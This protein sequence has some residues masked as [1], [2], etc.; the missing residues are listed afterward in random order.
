MDRGYIEQVNQAY[1]DFFVN[2]DHEKPILVIDSNH[3]DYVN[4]PEDLRWVENRIRQA[5]QMPPF[6]P[7][8]PLPVHMR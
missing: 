1:D 3:L 4:Y 7:E 6:Q 5:I 2:I 8:L